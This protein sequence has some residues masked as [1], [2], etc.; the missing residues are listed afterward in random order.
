[1]QQNI[2]RSSNIT[3]IYLIYVN[4]QN[5]RKREMVT[6]RFMDKKEC[7]F[8]GK[9]IPNFVKPK[10][11]TPA[12]IQV[13]T[14]DGVYKT[15]INIFDSNVSLDEVLYIVS[16]PQKWDFIQLRKSTRKEVAL[17]FSIKFNDGFEINGNTYDLATGGISFWTKE[18]LSSIYQ[19][20][21][22]IL[23][24]KL[25]DNTIINFAEGQLT[26]EAKFVREKEDLD[27]HPGEKLYIFRFVTL[28]LD[29]EMVLKNFL[30]K[31]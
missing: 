10:K 30:I 25:P 22:C 11:K 24:L 6:L 28:S 14:P 19:K 2:L 7:Y 13:F 5:A 23:T 4:P 20:I 16:I 8:V 15:N 29:D 26:T 27:Y 31:L 18:R 1:M 21:S 3:K 12:E 17:P 9:Y